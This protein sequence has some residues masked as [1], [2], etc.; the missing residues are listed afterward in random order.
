MGADY[1]VV[2]NA[3]WQ[4]WVRNSVTR[5]LHKLGREIQSDME[6][7]APVRSGRLRAGMYHEVNRGEL[8][9]G[10][11]DVPYWSTVEFGSGPHIITPNTKKALSWPGARHPV[12][13]VMHPGT[14]AQPFMRPALYKHRGRL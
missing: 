13:R 12:N 11:R 1:R 8:R 4:G 3:G 2:V 14:P 10:V 7:M 5:Y 6:R 9:V